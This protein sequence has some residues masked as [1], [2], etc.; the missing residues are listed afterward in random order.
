MCKFKNQKINI[1][2]SNLISVIIP[3]YNR[4]EFLIE[5]IDSVLKQK[6]PN[7]EIIIIDDNSSDETEER[8]NKRYSEF[9]NI[10]YYKNKV[11]MGPGY[12]RLLGFNKANGEYI[13]FLDDDDYYTD[14]NFFHDAIEKFNKNKNLAFVSGNNYIKNE[15]EDNLIENKLNFRKKIT[16]IEYLNN[17]QTLKYPK[18][19]ST[20]T[21]IFNKKVLENVKLNEVVMVNDTI[22]YLRALLGGNPDFIENM[23]GVYRVHKNNISK[24]C[25]TDFIIQNLDEK[26]KIYNLAMCMDNFKKYIN[27]NWLNNQLFLTLDYYISESTINFKDYIKI[28][29][30]INKNVKYRKYLQ[31]N[32]LIKRAIKKYI[33]FDKVHHN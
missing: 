32:N 17:F 23:V 30:W 14:Y 10:Y 1:D 11:N 26:Y 29:N 25:S 5:A 21:T 22:I 18:P 27:K 16:C 12:N 6:Y 19:Q 2:Y 4:Q 20:F 15:D 7:I 8:V 24:G 9:S 28:I 33:L 3:T 13:I 31:I